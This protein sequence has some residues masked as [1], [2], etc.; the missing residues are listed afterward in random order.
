MSV[1]PTAR[2]KSTGVF[3]AAAF[4]RAGFDASQVLSGSFKFLNQMV[5]FSITLPLTITVKQKGFL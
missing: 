3:T 1:D 2:P 5:E 4:L